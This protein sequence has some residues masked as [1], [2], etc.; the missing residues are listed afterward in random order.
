MLFLG[1]SPEP[2]TVVERRSRGK[3]IKG[4]VGNE[5]KYKNISNIN[6]PSRFYHGFM[7]R[8]DFRVIGDLW[9]AMI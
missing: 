4:K 8:S 9:I 2:L 5:F 1:G 7:H 3:I 6:K